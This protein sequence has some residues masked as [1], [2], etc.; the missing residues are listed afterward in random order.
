MLTRGMTAVNRPCCFAQ[1]YNFVSFVDMLDDSAAGSQ[2]SVEFR[3]ARAEHGWRRAP[4]RKE[5]QM[6]DEAPTIKPAD[7][8]EADA[9]QFE[10]LQKC[11]P[12]TSNLD[13]LSYGTYRI[14]PGVTSDELFHR[15]DEAIL[16][17]LGGESLSVDVDG[18]KFELAY[19]DT[20][21]VPL[22]TAYRITNQSDGEGLLAVCRAPAETKHEPF[23]SVWEEIRTN[24]ARIRHLDGKDVFL[25]FDVTEK[26]DKLMAGYTIYEPFTRAW[27]PHNH[28]DQEE[29]YIFT[30]G[31]GSMEVYAEEK[32]KTFVHSM[33]TLD[34]AT[35]PVLNYHPVFSQDEELHFIW[36][37]AGKRY[38]VGDKHKEFMDASVDELAT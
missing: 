24:E 16:F 38:W 4:T 30:E 15:T 6:P 5:V 28:T 31:R 19:Y 29:I 33:D 13:L 35:I 9:C 3:L 22:A 23:H 1:E 18:Q 11:N 26:A 8:L 7:L 25:M 17:C 21:Y 2:N 36:C 37:L 27:P 12:R 10:Y 20:L 14:G 34:A 32:T